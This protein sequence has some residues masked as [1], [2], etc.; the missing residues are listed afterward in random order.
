MQYRAALDAKLLDRL[1]VVHLLAAKDEPLLRGRN[2]LLLFD[3]LLD[4]RDLVGSVNVQLDLW[5]AR[6]CLCR[7][8]SLPL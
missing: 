8:V 6:T 2:A 5:S 7:S 4:P 1:F 3:T